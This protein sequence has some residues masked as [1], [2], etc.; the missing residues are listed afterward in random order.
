MLHLPPPMNMPDLD[1][2]DP[3]LPY[4]IFANGKR[5]GPVKSEKHV[6]TAGMSSEKRDGRERWLAGG[7]GRM[8][9]RIVIVTGQLSP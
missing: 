3:S 5:D 7:R 2:P 8:G 4:D 9:L 1:L 6:W